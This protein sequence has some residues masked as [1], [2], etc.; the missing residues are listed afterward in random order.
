[1]Y[2]LPLPRGRAEERG[3]SHGFFVTILDRLVNLNDPEFGIE[4]ELSHGVFTRFRMEANVDGLD[5][6]ITATRESIKES[7]ALSDVRAYLLAVFNAARTARAEIE[8]AHPETLTASERIASPPPALSQ[9]P[10][11]RAVLR[12]IDEQGD[13]FLDELIVGA[14]RGSD[15]VADIPDT[16][17]LLQGIELS[18]LG[19]EQ[20]I[21]SYDATRRI[22]L[23]N[24]DH[25][26]IDNY[27]DERGAVEP[28]QLLSATELF[29]SCYLLDE[30]MAPRLVAD[31]L[32]R[33]DSYLRAL[34]SIH[35]RSAP[36]V[37]RQLRSAVNSE[38]D[39]EDAVGDAMQLLGYSVR[40]KSRS[41]K[42]DIL[43]KANLGRRDG[44]ENR[45]YAVV[46]DAKSTSTKE[47]VAADKV[48]LGPLRK[49]RRKEHAKYILVVAPGFEGGTK[50]DSSIAEYCADGEITPITAYD[51][52]R[53]V[54]LFPT[55][56]I[57]PYEL[58]RLFAECHSPLESSQ[59]VDKLIDSAPPRSRAPV[60]LIL[61]EIEQRSDTKAPVAIK[62]LPNLICS[63]TNGE[64]DLGLEEVTSLIQGIQ[65]L[66][67]TTIWSDS[68][69]IALQT[70]P[71]KVKAEI[72]SNLE[73]LTPSLR[74]EGLNALG[75]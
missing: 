6:A 75:V 33:R 29:T 35:P 4:T 19:F 23:V 9:G 57:D 68:E 54:E 59:F 2:E 3:R 10:L 53:I 8:K 20:R 14:A 74:D 37:A 22:I 16:E 63:S 66:A 31:I 11:R 15:G 18:N 24:R 67:P 7:P 25:P 60:D 56:R 42:T 51:L 36:V 72:R 61:H 52:A 41:G 5:P 12:A 13:G 49:H 17:N 44:T 50:P 1:M 40:R 34:V 38:K 21:A 58:E 47:V 27:I 69:W 46:C 26:F 70:T 43:A 32:N 62:G 45:T 64:Y 55:R 65:A 71:D 39:L 30:G 73:E 48:N 28:L